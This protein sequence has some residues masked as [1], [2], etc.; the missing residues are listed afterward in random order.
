MRNDKLFNL[1]TIGFVIAAHIGLLSLAWQ[2]PL[3][4]VPA[5]SIQFVDLGMMGGGDGM[6]G[7]ANSVAEKTPL[8][9]AEKVVKP[10]TQPTKPK[11]KL[12]PKP[13]V[14]PEAKSVIKPVVNDH[15]PA[16]VVAAKEQPK[17]KKTVDEQPK[18]IPESKPEPKPSPKAEPEVVAKK[19]ESVSAEKPTATAGAG[20][21]TQQGAAGTGSGNSKKTGSGSGSGTGSGEASGSGKG[22][23]SAGSGA[24]SSAG[25]PIK[26]SGHI[27]TPPYPPIARENGEEGTV[28]LKIL[29]S[30]SGS[31]SNV[32]IAKSSGSARLDRAAKKAAQKGTFKPSGWTEYTVPVQFILN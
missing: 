17:P 7:M 29:V 2:Q 4:S 14:K 24:G 6:A 11:P 1:S 9:K 19:S 3:K 13:Q 12:A 30:P 18:P 10:V 21:A 26:A 15:K 27:P 25:N 31:V 20:S 23:A 16:D 5:V 28:V 22:G 32:K 8:Q